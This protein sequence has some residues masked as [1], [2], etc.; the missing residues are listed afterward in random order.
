MVRPAKA[1][2]N[3]F[4]VSANVVKKLEPDYF[5]LPVFR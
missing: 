1:G 2:G 3:R 4:P 5:G